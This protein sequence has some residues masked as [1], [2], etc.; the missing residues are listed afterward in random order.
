[1]WHQHQPLYKDTRHPTPRGSYRQ[2]WVRLHYL[3]DYYSRAALMADHPGLHLTINLTPVLLWQ[4]TDYLEQGATDRAL[5]LTLKPAET[6]VGDE[7]AFVLS[8]FFDA[9]WHHQIYPQQN[10]VGAFAYNSLGI[11]IAAGVLFP[12]FGLLLLPLLVGAAMAASSVAVVTNA[13]RLQVFKTKSFTEP[14]RA[15]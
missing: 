11:P 2:P 1:M 8:E 13:N 14:N 10:L 7:R 15:R 12:I 3:R 4:L 5:E 6:L 9:D